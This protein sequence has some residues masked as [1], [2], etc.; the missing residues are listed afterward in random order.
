MVRVFICVICL[1]FVCSEQS[2]S[3]SELKKKVFQDCS[4]AYSDINL[5]TPQERVEFVSYLGRILELHVESLKEIIPETNPPL[6]P[7]SSIKEPLPSLGADSLWHIFEP[8]REQEVQTCAVDLLGKL[9]TYSLPTLAKLFALYENEKVAKQTKAIIPETIWQITVSAA[10]EDNVHIPEEIFIDVI[11]RIEGELSYLVQNIFIELHQY[12]LDFLILR[13]CEPNENRRK[14]ISKLLRRIDR[15]GTLIGPLLIPL[16]DSIDE[17][18]ELEVIHLLRRGVEFYPLTAAPLLKKIKSPSENIRKAAYSAL[19][20]VLFNEKINMQDVF[21][22]DLVELAYSELTLVS[23]EQRQILEQVLIIG[24]ERLANFDEKVSSL[25]KHPDPSICAVGVR[26]LGTETEKKDSMRL[27]ADALYNDAIEVRLAAVSALESFVN[28]GEEVTQI[29]FKTL[30]RT[31]LREEAKEAERMVS[32]IARVVLLYPIDP[33]IKRMVPY[34]IE[35]LSFQYIF[36]DNVS[37]NPVLAVLKY[38]GS[39]AQALLVKALRNES[40]LVRR[41]AVYVLSLIKPISKQTL[42]LIV[43]MLK[44]S[45][46]DVQRAAQ[47][48]IR[49]LGAEARDELIEA[50]K[51][52]DVG[53]KLLAANLLLQDLEQRGA[54]SNVYMQAFLSISCEQ[55]VG[56]I[57]DLKFLE[58]SKDPVIQNSMLS[59]FEQ[60]GTNRVLVLDSLSQLSPLN[61]RVIEAI[62]K[63]S[64]NGKLSISETEFI[65]EKGQLFLLSPDEELSYA[66]LLLTQLDVMIKI[67]VL[68]VLQERKE[69]AAKMLDLLQVIFEDSSQDSSLRDN[70][71]YTLGVIGEKSDEVFEYLLSALVS[72]Q[73]ERIRVVLMNGRAEY[74]VAV[75]LK[76]FEKVKGKTEQYDII[77]D[78]GF[79]GEKAIAAEG[80]LYGLTNS[81]DELLRY[82][83]VVSLFKISSKKQEVQN[84][85]RKELIGKYANK[86]LAEKFSPDIKPVFETMRDASQLFVEKMALA[87]LIEHLS[88][89]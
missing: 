28:R 25:L 78:I 39:D 52:S 55:K 60:E 57:N 21:S 86:L 69:L 37:D 8:K 31:M 47:L 79:F 40:S 72:D 14:I 61:E 3:Q 32:A 12:S 29:L 30:K 48:G 80:I 35:S 54:V 56:L 83:A 46:I 59:C 73:R 53:Q 18:L 1:L 4:Q 77:R 51:W 6:V 74:S 9:G 26:L 34:F 10:G 38:I 58:L 64:V 85:F 87:V 71:A 19:K 66:R 33:S 5:L 50:L 27:I 68:H 44:D 23:L 89:A 22:S 62:R 88:G 17:A 11:A 81:D 75:L 7:S 84:V 49:E 20:D 16:L 45:S 13:F 36:L 67:K 42:K 70:V 76:V 63:M 82:K 65:F 41:R 24:E 43:S 2:V 15:K